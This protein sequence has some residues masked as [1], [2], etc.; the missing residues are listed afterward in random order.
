MRMKSL[1]RGDNPS[2]IQ[3][4]LSSSLDTD[5]QKLEWIFWHQNTKVMCIVY[6]HNDRTERISSDGHVCPKYITFI[7]KKI[8][9]LFNHS[10][11]W[12]SNFRKNKKLLETS[13][14]P[15]A[16][17]ELKCNETYP[18]SKVYLSNKP[19]LLVFLPKSDLP[20]FL[21]ETF[22]LYSHYEH[23]TEMLVK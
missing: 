7:E 3:L 20:F 16:P 1:S 14:S 8:L 4:N 10:F 9:K 2:R 6:R 18:L 13:L 15:S 21:G 17:F 5:T 23:S 12:I 11:S 22:L 19:C